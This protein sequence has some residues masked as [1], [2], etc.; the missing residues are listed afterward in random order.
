VG[1]KLDDSSLDR[2]ISEIDEDGSG[3]IDMVEFVKIMTRKVEMPCTQEQLQRAFKVFAEGDP[4]GAISPENLRQMMTEYGILHGI[5]EDRGN[6]LLHEL[7]AEI[8]TLGGQFSMF[9]NDVR[10]FKYNEYVS[11]MLADNAKD[12][13]RTKAA[14]GGSTSL[15]MKTAMTLDGKKKSPR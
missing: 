1:L 2:L 8:A 12:L 6:K 7:Q 15:S 13:R 4:A 3:E 10:L 9:Q 14:P 11:M 5:T